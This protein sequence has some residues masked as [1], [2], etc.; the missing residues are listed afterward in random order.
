MK[1]IGWILVVIGAILWFSIPVKGSASTWFT[2]TCLGII[3]VGG[4]LLIW[5]YSKRLKRQQNVKVISDYEVI[6][7]AKSK[8]V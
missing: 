8:G 2:W 5:Q 4:I 7:S 6:K 1:L 3:N